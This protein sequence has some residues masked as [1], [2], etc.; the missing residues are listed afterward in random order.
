VVTIRFLEVYMASFSLLSSLASSKSLSMP[1]ALRATLDGCNEHGG[2]WTPGVARSTYVKTFSVV[3]EEC[4]TLVVVCANS[5][6]I[7]WLK[8]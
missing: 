6:K 5:S 4:R 7:L 1:L 8:L 2:P 3:F